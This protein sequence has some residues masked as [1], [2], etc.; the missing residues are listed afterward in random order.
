MKEEELLLKRLYLGTWQFGGQFKKMTI[1]EIKNVIEKALLN[2]IYKFD[3]AHTYGQGMVESLLG[4]VLPREASILTKIPAINKNLSGLASINDA[5]PADHIGGCI[6]ESLKRL[7]RKSIDVILLHNW[8]AQWEKMEDIELFFSKLKKSYPIGLVGISL[9]D[10][11][12]RALNIGI[13]DI[14]DVV[15]APYNPYNTWIVDSIPTFIKSEKEFILRSIFMQGILL[16]NKQQIETLSFQ[17]IRVQRALNIRELGPMPREELIS[18]AWG[19]G[20]SLVIGMTSEDQIV[21]NTNFIRSL[22]KQ[23][24]SQ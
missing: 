13:V 23:R 3:T 5:Y 20:T 12:N 6:R 16:K 8:S 17:D 2:G 10:N 18:S 14:I 24:S 19:L 1:S 7:K 11:F 4:D 9:P 21:S 15:E 22:Q